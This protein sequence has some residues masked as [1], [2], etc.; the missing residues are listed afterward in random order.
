MTTINIIGA[1]NVAYH[2][3]DAISNVKELSLQNIYVRNPEKSGLDKKF[4]AILISDIAKLQKADL[5]IISITDLAIAEVSGQIP[6]TN[7]LVVHTSGT[8]PMTVLNTKNRRGVFYPLQT[9]SKS[10]KNVNFKKIP[11]CLETENRPDYEIL[12]HVAHLLSDSVHHINE[13]QRKSLHVAAVFVN[14]FVNHLYAIGAEIC[15]EHDVPFDILK[16]LIEETTNKIRTLSPKEAQTGPAIRR[17]ELT[18]QKHLEFIEEPL[19]RT[20]YKNLTA[21]IQQ[22]NDKEL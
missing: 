14:N 8:T 19:I 7:Q 13:E 3:M 21:S 15:E 22:Q 20:I 17:D 2:L 12:E 18:I 16:P 11:M 4:D 9:F 10:K 1:G 6:F 5:T